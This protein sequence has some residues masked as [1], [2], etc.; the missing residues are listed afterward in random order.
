MIRLH[1]VVQHD[2]HPLEGAYV[3]LYGPSGE[4]TAE[5]RTDDTGHFL[6]YPA[7]GRWKL[8][9]KAPGG[10]QAERAVDLTPGQS[11][12]VELEV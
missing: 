10:L 11:V 7:E 12:D 4:F 6:F 8:Q 2:G 1:G 3:M 9:A 5:R